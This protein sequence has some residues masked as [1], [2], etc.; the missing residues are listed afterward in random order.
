MRIATIGARLAAELQ[1]SDLIVA[2]LLHAYYP[3]PSQLVEGPAA[4]IFTNIA[5]V[6]ITQEQT[7][8]SEL[9]VRLLV[10]S[11]GRLAAEINALEPLIEPIVDHFTPTTAAGRQAYQLIVPG[12]PG[13]VHHCFPARFQ[14]SET[15]EYAGQVYSGI[16]TFFAVKHHRFAGEP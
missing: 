13:N 3:A 2:G 10:P 5:A 6:S 16:T 12:E 8:E 14:L 15:I 11:K 1:K 4:L 7:W 9:M